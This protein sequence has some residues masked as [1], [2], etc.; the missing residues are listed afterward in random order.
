M[1]AG[2]SAIFLPHEPPFFSNISSVC[3]VVRVD[4]SFQSVS[5]REKSHHARVDETRRVAETSIDASISFDSFRDSNHPRSAI[6]ASDL[7]ARSLVS[8]RVAHR[9]DLIDRID[10]RRPPL[11]PSFALDALVDARAYPNSFRNMTTRN[12]ARGQ[13]CP[14]AETFASTPE[15]AL[16][17]GF[18]LHFETSGRVEFVMR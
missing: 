3:V 13:K 9:L 14:P 12:G 11:A 5:P 16:Y 1:R 2:A 17:D 18:V 4:R 6:I 8:R 10:R 7:S 15:A